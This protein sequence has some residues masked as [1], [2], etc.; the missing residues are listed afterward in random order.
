MPDVMGGVESHCEEL[1]PRI[2]EISAACE[3]IVVT[4]RQY[5][6]PGRQEYEGIQLAHLPA[7]T[8]KHLEAPLHTLLA[9]L[10]AK[11]VARSCI[12]HI[13]AIGPALFAPFARML[14]LRVIVTHHGKDY[15]REKWGW[16]A[17]AALRFGEWCAV[18]FSHKII[19]VSDTLTSDLRREYPGH[20]AKFVA[21]R[22]GAPIISESFR[23]KRTAVLSGTRNIKS[24]FVL[25]VGRL[26]PEKGFHDLIAAFKRAGCGRQLI[27]IGASTDATDE[28]SSSLRSQAS[29]QILFLGRLSRDELFEY[30]K[31][32]SLFVVPSYHEGLS[33]AALEGVLLGAPT[34]MSDIPSNLEI[35]LSTHCYYRTGD[36]GELT[37]KLQADPD[38][39][40]PDSRRIA[41][42]FDWDRAAKDTSLVY[43]EV[44]TGQS[45]RLGSN[46]NNS[47][48][49]RGS[50]S[51]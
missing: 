13:H 32:C 40:V 2:K 41:R 8:S 50:L 49:S 15:Q 34:V 39:F 37:R 7:V 25:A 27:I 42:V 20:A 18:K 48:R 11:F 44:A 35:G 24:G 16:V 12:V 46:L 36:I 43:S 45:S 17:K 51:A 19:V 28:Y 10:H 30:Y 23:P 29:G 47:L 1:L 5:S 21:I 31:A 22:N 38:E 6:E 26:T 14:G 4:R 3:I 9:V 33:I